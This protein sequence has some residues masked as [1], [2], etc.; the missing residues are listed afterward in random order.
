MGKVRLE[1]AN[2]VQNSGK[3]LIDDG[4]QFLWI[5]DFPLF[6]RDENGHLQS[7]HHPFT[8][9]HPEDLHLLDGSP[10]KVSWTGNVS[11]IIIIFML[12]LFV[13]LYYNKN[14]R[15]ISMSSDYYFVS[16][17]IMSQTIDTQQLDHN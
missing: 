8:A 17:I 12:C 1:Y 14:S 6:E 4:M 7:A 5:T 11:C 9:P 15:Y 3:R 13:I 10:E 16:I 2:H